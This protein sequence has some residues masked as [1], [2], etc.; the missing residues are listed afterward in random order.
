LKSPKDVLALGQA[1]VRQLELDDRGDVL[2]RWLAHHLAELMAEADRAVGASKAK[3]E[4]Q[5]VE[6]ILKLWTHRRALPEPVDPLGG[7][8]DAIAV[9]S[10]LK[11]DANPWR[12]YRRHESYEDLLHEMFEALVRI[13]VGGLVLTQVTRPRS[14]AEA[15]AKALEEKEIFLHSELE[16]WAQF[17]AVPP[18]G[19]KIQITFVDSDAEKD[20]DQHNESTDSDS[21]PLTPEQQ[22]ADAEMS[23]HSIIV[24]N[25]ERLQVDLS[26]L[27]TRWRSVVPDASTQDDNE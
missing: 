20:L 4:R 6:T 18:K 23:F 26:S 10:R 9:I 5:V 14:I 16:Q 22:P 25:L 15:E 1:I 12:S 19:P 27:L 3:A 8:R 11:P 2:Q 24:A 7:Y 17:F 21:E 13:V